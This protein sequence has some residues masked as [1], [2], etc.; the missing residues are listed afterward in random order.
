M[1]R[2]TLKARPRPSDEKRE[3]AQ[4]MAKQTNNQMNLK[5]DRNCKTGKIKCIWHIYIYFPSWTKG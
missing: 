3:G 1:L 5:A 4:N 2:Y